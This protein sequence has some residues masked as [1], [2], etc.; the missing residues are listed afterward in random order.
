[1]AEEDLIYGKNRHFFGGIEPSNMKSFTAKYE[2]RNGVNGVAIKATLPDDTIVDDQ[3]LCVVGGLVIRKR[4]NHYVEDEFDGEE[5][6]KINC[7]TNDRSFSWFDDVVEADK[8]YY[9]R[10]FPFSAQGVY[11]RS[12]KNSEVAVTVIAGYTPPALSAF[13]G[14]ISFVNNLPKVT[15]TGSIQRNITN[16]EG[17]AVD[18]VATIMIRRSSSA[19]PTSETDGILVQ[20]L[21][22]GA[23]ESQP[24][25]SFEIDDTSVQPNVTY[26]YTAFPKS[27]TGLY[28]YDSANHTTI[29]IDIGEPP[30]PPKYFAVT[31]TAILQDAVAV[32]DCDLPD[33]MS[34]DFPVSVVIKRKIGSYPS[35][36]NDGD[37]VVT[38]GEDYPSHYSGHHRFIDRGL[39]DTTQYYY[40]AF[41]KNSLGAMNSSFSGATDKN[42][43][44]KKQWVFG[45]EYKYGESDPSASISYDTQVQ[46]NGT[47]RHFDNKDFTP[48]SMN[49]STGVPNYGSW[50]N[51]IPGTL[52][53]PKPCIINRN[54]GEVLCYL[55]PNDYS[56]KEDTTAV[57]VDGLYMMEFPRTY[58]PSGAANNFFTCN[59]MVIS[60]VPLSGGNYEM[61]PFS[62]VSVKGSILSSNVVYDTPYEYLYVSIYPTRSDDK[63]SFESKPGFKPT[64]SADGYELKDE[65]MGL[66]KPSNY[67]NNDDRWSYLLYTDYYYIINLLVLMAKTTDLQKAY[68]YGL[69]TNLANQ[70]VTASEWWTGRMDTKGLFY[71]RAMVTNNPT[72]DI[73]G[74]KTLGIEN[75]WGYAPTFVAGYYNHMWMTNSCKVGNSF[76][77]E[78]GIFSSITAFRERQC[79]KSVLG[80][81]DDS[82]RSTFAIDYCTNGMKTKYLAVLTSSGFKDISQSDIGDGYISNLSGYHIT[83]GNAE[84][85]GKSDSMRYD[86][87]LGYGVSPTIVKSGRMT[88]AIISTS[89][90][91]DIYNE[92]DMVTPCL[93]G[94]SDT[95]G[96]DFVIFTNISDGYVDFRADWNDQQ[97]QADK[98]HRL[99]STRAAFVGAS[100]SA[101]SP[102]QNGP[103]CLTIAKD[104]QDRISHVNRIVFVNTISQ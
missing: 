63:S 69:P 70:P 50:S 38:F 96:C 101:T 34:D 95:Y 55:N 65:D 29:T 23:S 57:D 75:L 52:F 8:T 80:R 58:I 98:W 13:N 56:Q 22:V 40:R 73:F 62:K 24:T 78:Y 27:G 44:A 86:A 37:T 45:F 47:S 26:Y 92:S 64:V 103:F 87:S 20:N 97:D 33:R 16:S 59:G 9:Y 68:G 3:T 14:S 4:K 104:T 7:T 67:H 71:G 12:L 49:L 60:N 74:V 76:T 2:Q 89:S 93:N 35:T 28:N 54:T 25:F 46:I 51:I 85:N 99:G 91:S 41:S 15:L 81:S 79:I 84:D 18:N 88:D 1:M 30:G 36:I 10:A 19:Y 6:I 90:I 102:K 83:K 43:R 11:S 77:T 21:T 53:M 82:D 61:S 48:F 42:I 39:V 94:S 100:A 72:N 31:A 66:L 17:T 32:I 5:V